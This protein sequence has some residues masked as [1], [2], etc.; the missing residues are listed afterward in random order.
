[1]WNLVLLVSTIYFVAITLAIYHLQQQELDRIQLQ[2]D[3]NSRVLD[4]MQSYLY[5]N[6]TKSSVSTSVQRSEGLPHE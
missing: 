3:E 6:S 5:I 1:M 4:R 2:M